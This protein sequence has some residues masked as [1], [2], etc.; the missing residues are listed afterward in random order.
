MVRPASWTNVRG[1]E[2][3]E[4][5]LAGFSPVARRLPETLKRQLRRWIQRRIQPAVDRAESINCSYSDRLAQ[6]ANVFAEQVEVHNLPPIFHYWADSHLRPIVERFGFSSPD[7]FF[8]SYIEKT[9]LDTDGPIR[10]ASIGSGNCDTEVRVAQMLLER[11]VCDFVIDCLELNPAMLERGHALAVDGGVESHIRTLEVDLNEWSA[12]A[13][14]YAV[15]L[16]NQSLHHILD[17]ERLFSIIDSALPDNGR[18]ITSDMIGRNGHMRWP[19]SLKIVNEFWKELPS[20]HRWNVQLQ[21]QEESFLD[22]DCSIEGFE[23]IRAQDILPLAVS[24]FDFEVFVPFGN[25]IDPFVDR[26]FGPHFDSTAAWD[27]DFIDRVHVR[28]ETEIQ[29]GRISP[30]HMMAVM[31]RRPYA[32]KCLL[33]DGLTPN[34][35][36]RNVEIG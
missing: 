7:E 4:R 36:I 6:E 13:G 35:C 33:R 18:F 11:D 27:R 16:A 14:E 34:R 20:D 2:G 19:E 29:A 1:G 22:W 10:V 32:G 31:R 15:F 24:A 28:D 12:S 25:V 23:G 26:S 30:T 5:V 21:R 8:L 3:V 17:L 9:A